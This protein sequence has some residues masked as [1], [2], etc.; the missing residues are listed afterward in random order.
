MARLRRL[1][2]PSLCGGRPLRSAA[3]NSASAASRPLEAPARRPDRAHGRDRR[4]LDVRPGL[5]AR[6]ALAVPHGAAA[7]AD[8]APATRPGGLEAVGTPAAVERQPHVARHPE[9]RV[10]RARPLVPVPGRRVGLAVDRL[11]LGAGDEAGGVEQVDR[12]V[13]QQ[14][15]IH[16]RHEALR[17]D[18]VADVEVAGQAGERAQAGDRV[19]ERE[20]RRHV[21]A[22]LA[23]HQQPPGG[24]RRRDHLAR[25][26]DRGGERLLGQ[27]RRARVQRGQRDLAVSL[28]RRHVDD[29]VGAGLLDHRRHVGPHRQLA[30]PQ[31][32]APLP[33]ARL[34]DV[35]PA[36]H[37]GVRARQQLAR[38]ERPE[39][40]RADHDAAQRAPAV[41]CGEAHAGAAHRT[42]LAITRWT[43][44]WW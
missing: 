15:V 38:P 21:A 32:V 2:R 22:V 28:R 40:P 5:H 34:V 13:E 16:R 33:C 9:D 30:E 19:A 10:G 1:S 18:A 4:Q 36:G 6:G 27:H 24:L 35:D 25:G 26:V 44:G 37:L 8:R 31:L 20:Q 17:F 41:H 43:S 11:R 12:H 7:L 3:T 39:E 29:E 23:D 14:R 42:A